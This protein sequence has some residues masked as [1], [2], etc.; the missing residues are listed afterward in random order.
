[1]FIHA[2]L[3]IYIAKNVPSPL[4]ETE[5]VR[6]DDTV[7]TSLYPGCVIATEMAS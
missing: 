1:M 5:K 3:L 6:H 7:S 4:K 2:F